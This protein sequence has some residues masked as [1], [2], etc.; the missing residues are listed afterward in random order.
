MWRTLVVAAVLFCG[1]SSSNDD[2]PDYSVMY[3]GLWT[4]TLTE[5]DTS[6]GVV[7]GTAQTDVSFAETSR[8]YFKFSNACPA[9]AGP[10]LHA[11]SAT[12]FASVAPLSCAA[13]SDDVCDAIVITWNTISGTLS[14]STLQFTASLTQVGCGVTEQLSATFVDAT[15][16]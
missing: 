2:S 11:T 10:V 9:F 14:S 15:K 16:D 12:E 3:A 13:Q 4:G 7:L 1:C 6:T 5:T 8:D